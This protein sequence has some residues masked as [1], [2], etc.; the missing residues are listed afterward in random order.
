MSDNLIGSSEAGR[1]RRLPPAVLALSTAGAQVLPLVAVLLTLTTG[2]C[3][4]S[5]VWPAAAVTLAEAAALGDSGEVLRLVWAGSDPA[6][7]YDVRAG[8]ADTKAIR[9]TPLE[10]A[11]GMRRPDTVAVL[12]HAMG[13][14]DPAVHRDL[15]CLALARNDSETAREL[16]AGGSLAQN[17]GG[18]EDFRPAWGDGSI[19]TG[20]T[21]PDPS[22]L[23]D[24]GRDIEQLAAGT[25]DAQANFVDDLT[26]L[27]SG[28]PLPARTMALAASLSSAIRG[29][30]LTPEQRDELVAALLQA[31]TPG[32]RAK[33]RAAVEQQ[34]TAAG[35]SHEAASA[36]GAAATQ[37]LAK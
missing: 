16:A 31:A 13:R 1:G 6:A 20:P 21:P 26:N 28:K 24:L 19:G 4:S 2:G 22:A 18:C 25:P 9:L 17:T 34:L 7:L 5:P 11:V 10:A 12:R 3:P 36:V 33:A 37:L 29:R 35:V 30:T 27:A 14:I 8:I 15:V 23:R 32:D